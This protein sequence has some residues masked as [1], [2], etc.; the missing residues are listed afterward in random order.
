MYLFE[1]KIEYCNSLPNTVSTTETEILIQL[2]YV[3]YQSKK[4]FPKN[5]SNKE[6]RKISN[7]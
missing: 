7:K 1:Q 3:N 2:K 6:K 4:K 5:N